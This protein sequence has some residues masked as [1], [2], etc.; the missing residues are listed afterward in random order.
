MPRSE[1]VLIGF[2]CGQKKLVSSEF[3]ASDLTKGL[4]LKKQ[5][6]LQFARRRLELGIRLRTNRGHGA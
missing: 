2:S 1:S 4:R 3:R 5:G 6:R